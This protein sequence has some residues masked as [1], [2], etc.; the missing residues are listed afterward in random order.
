MRWVKNMKCNNLAAPRDNV[1]IACLLDKGKGMGREEREAPV[2]GGI[3][4][5]VFWQRGQVPL[6]WRPQ[7]VHLPWM[8]HIIKTLHYICNVGHAPIYVLVTGVITWRN[9]DE[10]KM[11]LTDSGGLN[12]T[13]A[14][15][16]RRMQ[17]ARLT[18]QPP[19]QPG[20]FTMVPFV[21]CFYE[22]F[23]VP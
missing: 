9:Q 21:T 2:F 20:Y 13:A 22:Q 11:D 1:E 23:P 4:G 19:R 18:H 12:G 15:L 16:Q 14:G 7:P 17:A 3:R 5:V 8:C 10:I 6:A